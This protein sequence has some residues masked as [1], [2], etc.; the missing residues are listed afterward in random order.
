MIKASKMHLTVS[1][2]WGFLEVGWVCMKFRS[3]NPTP[4]HLVF[5]PKIEV[6]V[7]FISNI[8]TISTMSFAESDTS[9][10]ISILL[11]NVKRL[12]AMCTQI[13]RQVWIMLVHWHFWQKCQ[14]CLFWERSSGSILKREWSTTFCFSEG[15]WDECYSYR[16]FW[17]WSSTDVNSRLHLGDRNSSLC[18]IILR[19]KT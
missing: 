15:L 14:L 1:K 3:D 16:W 2:G 12:C 11:W 13:W 6:S 4:L 18:L 17:F 5:L 7:T 10:K 19:S 8:Y 9:L